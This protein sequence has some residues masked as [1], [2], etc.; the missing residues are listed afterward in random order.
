MEDFAAKITKEMEEFGNRLARYEA[1]YASTSSRLAADTNG[2]KPAAVAV[3][4]P[5]VFA[6]QK[7]QANQ[8]KDIR[9][10]FGKLKKMGDR[11]QNKVED[12]E[13]KLDDLEQYGRSNCLIIHRCEEVPKRGEYLEHEKYVCG[14]LNLNLKLNPSLQVNDID[15]AHPLPAKNNNCPVIVKFL[16]R[17]QRNY[18]FSQKRLL[19][20]KQMIITESLTKRRLQRLEAA[21][22][23]FGWRSVWSF[24]GDVYAF[25]GGKKKFIRNLND[26]V[27]IKNSM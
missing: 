15:I 4:A 22:D 18:F 19:K 13:Q 20:G 12:Q 8:F 17:S 1:E 6:N 10:A 2:S 21:R 16:R 23:V 9:T 5:T 27:E 24:N 3:S 14:L 11:L 7:E 25:A 26:I